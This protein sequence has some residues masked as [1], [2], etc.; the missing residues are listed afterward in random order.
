MKEQAP[1]FPVRIGRRT[2]IVSAAATGFAAFAA[3]E[4]NVMHEGLHTESGVF[5]PLYE[6]HFFNMNKEDVPDRL[7]GYFTEG[8]GEDGALWKASPSAIINST[9]QYG[10][11]FTP[12]E[13]LEKLAKNKTKIML[14]DVDVGITDISQRVASHAIKRISVGAVIAGTGYIY[15]DR[16]RASLNQ[17]RFHVGGL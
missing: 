14:G 2:A 1:G 10:V 9:I 12:D 17:T 16:Y 3:R 13:I 11:R 15:M 6:I 4:I 8:W 7:D 5:F